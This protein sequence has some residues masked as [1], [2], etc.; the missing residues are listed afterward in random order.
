[1]LTDA[2]VAIAMT[3]LILPLVE[4]SGEVEFESLSGF[5]EEHGNQV[6]SFVISFLVIFVFWSAHGTIYR[7]LNA[8]E[9]EQVPGLGLLNMCWLLVIAFLPFPTALVG[10]D[11]T[12]TSAP[13]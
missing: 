10:R 8:A 12:T 9:I 11:L 7:R 13:V 4:I 5:L 6:M 2:V 3:L 1:M